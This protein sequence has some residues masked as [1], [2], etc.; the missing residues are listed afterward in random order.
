MLEAAA[1]CIEAVFL[2]D[3]SFYCVHVGAFWLG[4]FLNK[5]HKRR[6]FQLPYCDKLPRKKFGDL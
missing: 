2:E 3:V 5:Y 6:I 1:E 4:N